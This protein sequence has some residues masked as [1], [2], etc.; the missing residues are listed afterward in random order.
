M[1]REAAIGALPVRK[2]GVREEGPASSSFGGENPVIEVCLVSR[3]KV[4][5]SPAW[6]D[7]GD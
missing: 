6:E 1:L 4:F 5:W 3:L 2:G 7:M